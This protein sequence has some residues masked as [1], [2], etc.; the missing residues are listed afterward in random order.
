MPPGKVIIRDC[1]DADM[2]R[3]TEI[4]GRSVRE[5]TASFELEP[6]DVQEMRRRRSALLDAGYPYLVAELDGQVEGYAYAG[7]YRPRPAYALAVENTVYVNPDLQRGGVGRA[8]M[9][10]LIAECETRGYR[11]MIAIIGDSTHVASIE[12][13]KSLGFATVG[14]IRS[15]GY[16][17]A[18]W[19]DTVFMQRA[20]GP[21]DK[22]P[23]DKA[24]GA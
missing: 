2:T 11:Q 10:V 6:P 4:Y 23:P 20:L 9:E 17:H 14:N 16:K 21:G 7:A 18:K 15:V 19:L 8:L 12:F 22:T 13:H 24:P 3:V 5:E 1:R